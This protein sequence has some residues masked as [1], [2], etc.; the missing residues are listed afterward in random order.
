MA[1]TRQAV[2]QVKNL[3]RTFQAVIDLADALGNVQ[4]VEQALNRANIELARVHNDLS[5]AKSDLAS[6]KA[7]IDAAHKEAKQ[8]V[9]DGEHAARTAVGNAQREIESRIDSMN[10]SLAQIRASQDAVKSDHKAELA[11]VSEAVD[12]KRAALLEIETKIAKARAAMAEMLK[13]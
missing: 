8:I 3:A 11:R 10:Q 4:S 1:D 13:G 6:A 5:A 12:I 2:E 9:A 7:G